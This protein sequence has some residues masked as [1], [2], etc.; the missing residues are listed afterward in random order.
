MTLKFARPDK[1]AVFPLHT[2]NMDR[3]A[4]F[5]IVFPAQQIFT[6]YT[7]VGTLGCDVTPQLSE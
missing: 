4:G 3:A 7:S 2:F 1:H 5:I 6:L